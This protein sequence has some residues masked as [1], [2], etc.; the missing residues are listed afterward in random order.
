MP[1]LASVTGHDVVGQSSKL[2]VSAEPGSEALWVAWVARE[3]PLTGPDAGEDMVGIP[4]DL[5]RDNPVPP[6]FRD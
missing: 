1:S 2:Q 6:L 5:F 3:E 4:A